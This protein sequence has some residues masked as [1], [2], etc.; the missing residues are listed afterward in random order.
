MAYKR[1]ILNKAE[2]VEKDV[3]VEVTETI[4]E[5]VEFKKAESKIVEPVVV[6]PETASNNPFMYEVLPNTVIGIAPIA[7]IKIHESD[8]ITNPSLA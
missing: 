4:E 8:T 5:K 2:T 3:E 6:K 7:P 1:K